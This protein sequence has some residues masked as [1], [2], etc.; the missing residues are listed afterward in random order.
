MKHDYPFFLVHCRKLDSKVYQLCLL[1]VEDCYQ[2]FHLTIEILYIHFIS[3][4]RNVLVFVLTPQNT[5][6]NKVGEIVI[7]AGKEMITL[8]SIESKEPA[9][10]K[11]EN[12]TKKCNNKIILY[13]YKH[14]LKKYGTLHPKQS[15]PFDTR[16]YS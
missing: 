7:Y 3:N 14:V 5:R 13:Y 16:R 15:V 11:V 9:H 1:S 2:R 4:K 6:L 8:C 12:R 10:I